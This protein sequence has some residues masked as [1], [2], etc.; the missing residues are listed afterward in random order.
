MVRKR[1][2]GAI[3]LTRQKVNSIAKESISLYD[4]SHFF[5][6]DASNFCFAASA[7]ASASA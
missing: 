5:F 6:P 2:I 1:I 3:R 4:E 7:L